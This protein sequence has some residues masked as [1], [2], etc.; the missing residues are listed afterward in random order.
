MLHKRAGQL[1]IKF[2]GDQKTFLFK[3]HKNE[4]WE[5]GRRLRWSESKVLIPAWKK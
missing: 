1:M 2:Y 3:N 5:D 4:A